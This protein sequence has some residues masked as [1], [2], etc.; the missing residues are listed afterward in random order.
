MDPKDKPAGDEDDYVFDQTN[1]YYQLMGL[2]LQEFKRSHT[3]AETFDYYDKELRGIATS[4][5]KF[6]KIE[7]VDDL[8][9]A[10]EQEI[11]A[12]DAKVIVPLLKGNVDEAKKIAA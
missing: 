8:W 6:E 4:K 7:D 5:E 10:I 11:G 2:I 1:S 9:P 3:W 12:A